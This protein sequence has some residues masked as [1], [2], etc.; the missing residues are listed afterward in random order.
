VRAR[1]DLRKTRDT[2]SLSLRERAR[3][4]GNETQPTKT[5]GSSTINGRRQAAA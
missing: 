3:V 2:Y 4:R 1:S 5:V